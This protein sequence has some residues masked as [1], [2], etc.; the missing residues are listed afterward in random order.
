MEQNHSNINS[1]IGNNVRSARQHA[2]LSQ[3][4]LAFK[5]GL[6]SDGVIISLIETGRRKLSLIE[7]CDIANN[8]NVN[9]S[10][11]IKKPT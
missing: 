8:C 10:D 1:I 6:E 3:E 5:I 9:I 7:A 2:N 11:L 4:E